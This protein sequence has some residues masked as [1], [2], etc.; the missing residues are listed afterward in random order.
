MSHDI[1]TPLNA[2]IGMT[3]LARLHMDD[4]ERLLYDLEQIGVSS[5]LLLSLVNEV[6]DMSKIESGKFELNNSDFNL[7]ELLEEV[8]CLMRTQAEEKNRYSMCPW[9]N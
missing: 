2:V 9:M 8:I 6:L 4:K 1:R 3:E 5:Q 7:H